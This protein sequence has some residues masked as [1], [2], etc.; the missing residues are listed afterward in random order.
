MRLTW[1]L[2]TC[3]AQLQDFKLHATSF[4]LETSLWAWAGNKSS[5]LHANEMSKS[6]WI[7]SFHIRLYMHFLL[8]KTEKSL[9]LGFQ[10]LLVKIRLNSAQCLWDANR[11]E[12]AATCDGGLLKNSAFLQLART[13]SG[14]VHKAIADVEEPCGHFPR[15]PCTAQFPG[16]VLQP[17][18]DMQPLEP[19][20]ILP[21]PLNS[22]G[23]ID[24]RIYS[25]CLL[26]KPLNE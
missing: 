26:V 9:L 15:G 12:K 17:W 5:S 20:K 1:Q 13:Q 10:T 18:L 19:W 25:T 8:I 6:W 3:T 4:Q 14:N 16:A 7:S 22:P 24:S 2:S 11:T 21:L 23:P